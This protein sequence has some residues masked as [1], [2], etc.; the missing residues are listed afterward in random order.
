M[1]IDRKPAIGTA[2]REAYDAARAKSKKPCNCGSRLRP[3]ALAG[4]K[5]L[6]CHPETAARYAR[7]RENPKAKR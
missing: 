4:G 1:S 5:C 3:S 6:A 7:M 2:A